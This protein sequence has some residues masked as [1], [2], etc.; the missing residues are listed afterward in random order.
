M[1]EREIIAVQFDRF[2]SGDSA[3]HLLKFAPMR[4]AC[5]TTANTGM[6]SDPTRGATMS[7]SVS[8]YVDVAGK[9]LLRSSVTGFLDVLGFSHMSTTAVTL[10]DSQ[11]ILERIVAAI[12]GSRAFVRD[13]FAD[14][15]IADPR[16]WALK[17]FSDN[18]VFGF[19]ADRE[20]VTPEQVA[21][22]AIRCVQGYQ[23]RMTLS[24]FFVRGGMTLGHIC[25]TDEIIF[26]S[27]L[28]ECY[29]LESHASIVPRVLLTEPLQ[30]LL[31]SGL[32]SA[33]PAWL[34]IED[35]ICRDVDGWWFINYLQAASTPRGI[36]WSMIEQHKTAVLQSLAKTTQHDVL[37]KFG[38][39]CRYHNVFCHWNRNDAGYADRYSI[40]RVDEQSSIH[41]LSDLTTR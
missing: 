39:A 9:P 3:L 8:P 33:P 5:D 34:S 21:Q 35:S 38:W 17:F 18:L 22:L 30:Q 19:P 6:Q 32:R 23:L 10:E 1:R 41:R 12:N 4:K 28:I 37:P 15:P 36:D 7:T 24:G 27:A 20:G 13:T 40:D 16:H 31:A 26:G 11:Q 14:E 2:N 29:R 25:L